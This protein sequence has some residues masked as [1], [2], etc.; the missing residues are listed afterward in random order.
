VL[1]LVR[2]GEAHADGAR[3][4]RLSRDEPA[5]LEGLDHLVDRWCGN[6][7]APLN[8]GFRRWPTKTKNVLGNET[9]VV[10]LTLGELGT[11]GHGLGKGYGSAD[12][13]RQTCVTCFKGEHDTIDKVDLETGS[14]SG[15]DVRHHSPSESLGEKVGANR[16][17]GYGGVCDEGPGPRPNEMEFSGERSESAATTG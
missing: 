11:S 15:G 14:L 5:P 12:M 8:I 1:G 13:G 2:D 4:A 10:E 6:K 7:K 3:H 9:Q 17:S 16:H